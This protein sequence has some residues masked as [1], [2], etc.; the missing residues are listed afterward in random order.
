MKAGGLR[1]LY[2]QSSKIARRQEEHVAGFRLWLINRHHALQF[3]SPCRLHVPV[4]TSLTFHNGFVYHSFRTGTSTALPVQSTIIV[5]SKVSKLQQC[6]FRTTLT[7]PL[8]FSNLISIIK[9]ID[10]QKLLTPSTMIS[11]RATKN[12]LVQLHKHPFDFDWEG[13]VGVCV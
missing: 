2:T 9:T 4:L 3:S 8:S 1:A 7:P 12:S 6:L 5:E 11:T 13:V 10:P